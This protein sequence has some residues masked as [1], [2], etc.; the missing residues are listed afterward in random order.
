MYVYIYI[1]HY[2]STCV[3]VPGET[4]PISTLHFFI[5][6]CWIQVFTETPRE[7]TAWRRKQSNG[8]NR[9]MLMLQAA[10][11]VLS[12]QFLLIVFVLFLFE[13]SQAICRIFRHHFATWDSKILR[14][15][16]LSQDTIPM[17]CFAIYPN[18]WDENLGDS[19]TR[20]NITSSPQ[21]KACLF[22]RPRPARAKPANLKQKRSHVLGENSKNHLF[23]S[24]QSKSKQ[25]KPVSPADLPDKHIQNQVMFRKD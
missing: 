18:W 20:M 8:K 3:C 4:I 2:I 16:N 13:R 12:Q 23:F 21:Q 25:L 5:C 6:L 17:Q 9:G 10:G 11:N 19:Y 22:V 1:Y 7:T 24:L 15:R 14:L